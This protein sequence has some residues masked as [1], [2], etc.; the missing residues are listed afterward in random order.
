M[1]PKNG[2]GLC[3]VVVDNICV[4]RGHE[5]LL[6]DISFTMHCSELTSL[7][8]LNGA[9]KTTLLRAM[10]DEIEHTGS[11]KFEG[12]DGKKLSKI[13]IGY[14]PQHLEFDKSAPVSVMDFMLAACSNKPV[15]LKSNKK[16]RK[17]I[18]KLLS[19]A[20]ATELID[21]ALGDL[22]GGEIQRVMLAQALHPIPEL[23]ILDE[24][25]SGIDSL[26]SEKFYESITN[27]RINYHIA[28]LMV[29]HDLDLI[30]K[31]SDNIILLNKKILKKGTSK[32]VFKSKEFKRTFNT[33]EEM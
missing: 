2:C 3:K 8:G 1:S 26:G 15:F 11:V 18:K 12:Y 9:G 23:L 21:K 27:L 17:E 24:P 33:E 7:I 10:L 14:V 31:H 32:E 25:L 6:K 16:D 5:T 19:I 4:E 28:V 20:G 22:S 29:S 13:N 30:Q